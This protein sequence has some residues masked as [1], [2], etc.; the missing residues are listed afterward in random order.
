MPTEPGAKP[1]N[2]TTLETPPIVTE[3]AAVADE[4]DLVRRL[5]AW[6]GDPALRRDAGNYARALV[7]SGVGAAERSYELVDRLLV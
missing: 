4:S 2:D 6:I 3:G 5:R 1:A 7:R